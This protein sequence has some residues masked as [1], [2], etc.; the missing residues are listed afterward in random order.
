MVQFMLELANEVSNL[1]GAASAVVLVGEMLEWW[2][3]L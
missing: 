3:L 2:D 1:A